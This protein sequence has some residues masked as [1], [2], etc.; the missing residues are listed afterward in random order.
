M[1]NSKQIVITVGAM[2]TG[3]IATLFLLLGVLSLAYPSSMG[4]LGKLGAFPGS[5]L[6]TA[7]VAVIL[8]IGLSLVVLMLVAVVVG[9]YQSKAANYLAASLAFLVGILGI[10]F[11]DWGLGI[12]VVAA[13]LFAALEAF[14]S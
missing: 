2:L 1:P 8:L 13:F 12:G 9:I 7:S 14:V 6:G 10:F 4:A 5:M 3:L 11:A